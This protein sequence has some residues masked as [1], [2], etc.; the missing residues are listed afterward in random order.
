MGA[1]LPCDEFARC[2]PAQPVN[3]YLRN[4]LG[5]PLYEM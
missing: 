4:S 5:V 1:T 3:T 2:A